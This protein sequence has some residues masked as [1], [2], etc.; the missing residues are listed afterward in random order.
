MDLM[1]TRTC[2]AK[3]SF[4]VLTAFIVG[5]SSAAFA[6]DPEVAPVAGQPAPAAPAP[7]AEPAP[8]PPPP[9]TDKSFPAT[10]PPIAEPTAVVG[11]NAKEPRPAGQ[12]TVEP[13]P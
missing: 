12:L 8:P 1:R 2:A 4:I 9:S 6:A 5:A 10:P 11:A 3:S 7:V 13:D